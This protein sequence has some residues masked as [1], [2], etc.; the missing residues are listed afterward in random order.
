MED[1]AAEEGR[2][3]IMAAP[4]L[5]LPAGRDSVEDDDRPTV[6]RRPTTVPSILS[7]APPAPTE[8][9]RDEHGL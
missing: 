4:P 1:S 9:K 5:R 8:G 2:I 6:Q 7:A 3:A